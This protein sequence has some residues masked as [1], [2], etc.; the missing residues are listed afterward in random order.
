ML[1]SFLRRFGVE[2]T[3]WPPND[4]RRTGRYQIVSRVEPEL[5]AAGESF[6][7]LD[8]GAG[9]DGDDFT[10]IFSALSPDLIKKH[11]FEVDAKECERL[12][13]PGTNRTYHPTSLCGL[14][15]ENASMLLKS[16]RG[17][18]S[19]NPIRR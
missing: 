11:A 18:P 4:C 3:R 2:V 6:S 1:K 16:R 10:A 12:K 5:R 8:A 13:A 19:M 9:G 15:A 14:K 7:L 17:I